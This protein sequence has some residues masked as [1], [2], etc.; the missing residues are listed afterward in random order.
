MTDEAIDVVIDCDAGVD[1]ALAL[2]YCAGTHAAHVVGITTVAGNTTAAQSARVARGLM[3]GLGFKEVPVIAGSEKMLHG[4]TPDTAE[5][6]HGDDAFGGMARHLPAA[7]SEDAD[8]HD[9]KAARFIV[10][11]ATVTRPLTIIALGPLTNLAR[12]L[13]LDESLPSRILR[14]VLMGGAIHHPGNGTPSAEANIRNDV[15]AAHEV[16]SAPWD[17]MVVPLDVTMHH[18]LS[19]QG[20]ARM[21]SADSDMIRLL[22]DAVQKYLDF[23]EGRHFIDRAAALHDP[24]TMAIALGLVQVEAPRLSVTVDRRPGLTY[25]ATIADTRAMYRGYPANGRENCRVVL[26][27]RGDFEHHMLATFDKM[28]S[29]AS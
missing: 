15:Q 27:V 11:H 10:E 19:A 24:L 4:V 2:A 25:G 26:G 6:V 1:D 22:G 7:P 23:H 16:L 20:A 21:R 3:H 18:R 28:K 14:V 17:V 13:R 5:L 29:V 9:L 8:P 12:A